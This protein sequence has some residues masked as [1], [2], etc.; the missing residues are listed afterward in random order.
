MR[1]FSF[2]KLFCDFN[3]LNPI[4]HINLGFKGL[5]NKIAETNDSVGV[6]MVPGHP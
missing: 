3:P 5:T 4:V 6:F 2:E 1:L